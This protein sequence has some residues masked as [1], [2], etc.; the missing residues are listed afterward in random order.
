[1]AESQDTKSVK[2]YLISRTHIFLKL[3]WNIH[4]DRHVLSDQ[5]HLKSTRTEV[6]QRL[7]SDHGGIKLEI[8]NGK[9][10]RKSP[11]MQGVKKHASK[12]YLV[13]EEISTLVVQWLRTPHFQWRGPRFKPWLGNWIHMLQLRVCMLQPGSKILPKKLG[14][15]T[16]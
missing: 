1:M 6:I 11:N 15:P 8:N 2:I 12:Y 5:T 9:I 16:L 4:Q 3:S 13:K 10:I 7:L 14:F